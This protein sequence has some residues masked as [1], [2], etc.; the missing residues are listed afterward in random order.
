MLNIDSL[1]IFAKIL[2]RENIYVSIEDVQTAMFDLKSRNLILPNWE[3][4]DENFTKMLIAHEVAH[5]IYTPFD[6]WENELNKIPENE[7]RLFKDI[8]NVIEDCRI[9]R[10]IQERYPGIKYN[11]YN[12]TK[13]LMAKDFFGVKKNK[14][15]LKDYYFI[16][17]VNLYFKTLYGPAPYEVEFEDKQLPVVEEIRVL[18]SFSEVI[19]LSKKLFEEFKQELETNAYDKLSEAEKEKMQKKKLEQGN[20]D[21]DGEGDEEAVLMP[22]RLSIDEPESGDESE[23]KKGKIHVPTLGGT[24]AELL[25]NIKKGQKYPNIA[26]NYGVKTGTKLVR[27]INPDHVI[28]TTWSQGQKS[29]ASFD[30]VRFKWKNYITTFVS[31]FERKK[32]ARNFQLT[33]MNKT[34]QLNP[35]KLYEYQMI[36]DIFLSK[37]VEG[38]QKNHAFLFLLDCSGSMSDIFDK[39]ATQFA[40]FVEICRKLDIPCRGY[41]FSDTYTPPKNAENFSGQRVSLL[42]LTDERRDKK[43][44]N[45][46][47]SALLDGQIRLGGT[48][49]G[50]SLYYLLSVADQFKKETRVDVLNVVVLTDGGDGTA[51]PYTFLQDAGTRA[52]FKTGKST[53]GTSDNTHAMYKMIRDVVGANVIHIDVTDAPTVGSSEFKQKNYT[54][55]K[56]YGGA[57]SVLFITPGMI[58]PE[59]KKIIETFTEILK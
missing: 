29:Q 30:N 31:S 28:N 57:S 33:R 3:F 32:N 35:N 44:N 16:D 10:L 36:E 6:E 19:E 26:M 39:V 5:A 56:D 27:R 43:T 9:D 42:E 52:I 53:R 18:Q 20:G 59:K 25:A 48:P 21:S 11:Y 50:D 45:K 14:K 51:R 47:I 40:V 2:A 15:P 13:Y 23:E 8:V 7:R 12:S 38:Y 46:K 22:S 24:Q 58:S 55:Q 49:L 41:G 34:G 54:L 4:E 17:K 1:S 37:E